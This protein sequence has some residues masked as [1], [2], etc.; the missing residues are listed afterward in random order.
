VILEG[1][2]TEYDDVRGDGWIQASNT[3]YY[4][5]CISVAD[6]SRHLEA[7]TVVIFRV[8]A[9]RSG[10]DEAGDVRDVAL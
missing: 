8:M 10:R 2:V 3:S 1:V 7:G 4:V 6:G 9:G 5:H